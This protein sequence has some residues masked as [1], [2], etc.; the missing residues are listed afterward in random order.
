MTGAPHRGTSPQRYRAHCPRHYRAH[1]ARKATLPG[2]LRSQRKHRSTYGLQPYTS[3]SGS[4]FSPLSTLSALCQSVRTGW[5]ARALLRPPQRLS[6]ANADLTERPTATL[7]TA[8]NA[9]ELVNRRKLLAHRRAITTPQHF[10]HSVS[11]LWCKRARGS[12]IINLHSFH[13]I[14]SVL[15]STPHI[16]KGVV[17]QSYGYLSLHV[18][19]R[20]PFRQI[21][22]FPVFAIGFI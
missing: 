20:R 12:N 2:S 6:R 13:N 15:F 8:V 4:Q 3:Y 5:S 19:N 10:S 14:R 7:H 17:I 22:A 9:G 18:L 16:P 1:F 11:A 21:F